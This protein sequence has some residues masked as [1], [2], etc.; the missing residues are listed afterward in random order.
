MWYKALFPFFITFGFSGEDMKK[1]FFLFP[2]VVIF[3]VFINFIAFAQ[4]GEEETVFSG[5]LRFGYEKMKDTEEEKF[6]DNFSV[7]FLELMVKKKVGSFG[8]F[9]NERFSDLN[10]N[11]LYEG[12]ISWTM[13]RKSG[14]VKAG[15]VPVPF[16]IF[17][18]NLYYPKGIL[19]DKNWMG[20]RDYGVSYELKYLQSDFLGFSLDGAYL[21]KENNTGEK[22]NLYELSAFDMPGLKKC[23]GERDT[24]SGRLGLNVGIEG[25]MEIEAGGSFQLG[26]IIR[27]SQEKE[28]KKLGFAGDISISPKMI[29][30]PVNI[31]GEFVNYKLADDDTA[32]GN[33][34]MAQADI[35]PIQRKGVLDSATLSLHASMI[36]PQEGDART[37]LIGQLMLQLDLQLFV[38]FQIFGDIYENGSDM[39][40]QGLALWLRYNF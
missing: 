14:I 31:M 7:H 9:L 36:M 2:V 18:N 30:I 22:P 1:V 5:N 26:K 17:Q 34:I 24:F 29:T 8:V 3:A 38:Y 35:T 23:R 28:D 39:T 37:N 11:H 32:K 6:D 10:E 12:W 21:N 20:D 15:L 25:F 40:N 27:E 19:F 13:P 4:E 16:G 33:I